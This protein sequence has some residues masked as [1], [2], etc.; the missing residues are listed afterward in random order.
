MTFGSLRD[1]DLV[2]MTLGFIKVII[3]QKL[4]ILYDGIDNTLHN[5]PFLAKTPYH[6]KKR[7]VTSFISSALQLF[8]L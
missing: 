5:N 3:L 6:E 8:I 7:L 2:S 4:A 1:A